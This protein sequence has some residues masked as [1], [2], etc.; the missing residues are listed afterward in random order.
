MAP[1]RSTN[2]NILSLAES[3]ISREESLSWTPYFH[4]LTL[5]YLER[6]MD[7]LVIDTIID[8]YLLCPPQNHQFNEWNDLNFHIFKNYNQPCHND[9]RSTLLHEGVY[10]G[11][12]LSGGKSGT[13]LGRKSLP[14]LAEKTVTIIISQS[15]LSSSSPS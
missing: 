11:N 10:E 12:D 14:S 8:D 13:N 1:I 15:S 5:L 3:I 9:H 6:A 4:Y 2:P 7:S